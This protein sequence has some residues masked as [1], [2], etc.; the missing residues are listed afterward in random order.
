MALI[1]RDFLAIAVT[2]VGV[3][4]LFNSARDIC[5]YRRSRLAPETIEAIMLQMCTDNFRIADEFKFTSDTNDLEDDFSSVF[6]ESMEDL[7]EVNYISENEQDEGNDEDDL[8][9]YEIVMVDEAGSD[10]SDSGQDLD[11]GIEFDNEVVGMAIED[12]N[13]QQFDNIPLPPM[14]TERRTRRIMHSPNHYKK[15]NNGK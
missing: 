8:D 1:A 12:L 13:S 5:H 4:S 2:S 10:D 14:S 9:I 15:I 7:K 11:D 3:E 6:D